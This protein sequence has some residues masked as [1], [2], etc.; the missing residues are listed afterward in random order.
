MLKPLGAH[1][2]L[3]AAAAWGAAAGTACG[4]G[5]GAGG[6]GAGAGGGGGGAGAGGGGGTAFGAGAGGGT[7]FAAG[8]GGGALGL[9]ASGA[10]VG[11]DGAVSVGTVS[12]AV[13]GTG[14]DDVVLSGSWALDVMGA[15]GEPSADGGGIGLTTNMKTAAASSSAT[16][17][18]NPMA[19]PF[20]VAR[21]SPEVVTTRLL[22]SRFDPAGP[23]SPSPPAGVSRMAPVRPVR[24]I[25]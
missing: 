2:A 14:D 7:A 8:A 13:V 9:L 18:T 5:A 6:G 25:R 23:G 15:T 24:L 3:G 19:G 22:S 17:A 4:A 11:V 10:D 20:E 1:G 16:R 21:R 12:V